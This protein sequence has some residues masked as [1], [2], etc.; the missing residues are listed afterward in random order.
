MRWLVREG[1]DGPAVSRNREETTLGA[2]SGALP[3]FQ[4]FLPS[5]RAGEG[6]TVGSFPAE[7]FLGAKMPGGRGACAD[8]ATGRGE[9]LRGWGELA[10][11]CSVR[12]QAVLRAGCPHLL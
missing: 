2:Q 1:P 4:L 9:V 10:A 11:H 12:F 7:G 8:S 6:V 5:A 3:I